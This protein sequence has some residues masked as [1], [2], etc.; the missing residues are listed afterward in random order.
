MVYLIYTRVGRKVHRLIGSFIISMDK[1]VSK[2]ICPKVNVIVWPEFKLTY[3]NV[4]SWWFFLTNGIQA[5]QYW[6]KMCP[7]EGLLKNKPYLV[8]F[9]KIIL[10]NLWTF[11]PTLMNIYIY[12]IL[13]CSIKELLITRALFR[14]LTYAM[15]SLPMGNIRFFLGGVLNFCQCSLLYFGM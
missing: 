7:Q 9:H 1:V 8:T 10:V 3:Y 12:I 15:I 14:N 13:F 4:I 5:L 11:Q 6:W 2:S